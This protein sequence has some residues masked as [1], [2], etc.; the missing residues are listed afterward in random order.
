MHG[1]ACSVFAASS[2]S[3][4][5]LLMHYYDRFLQFHSNFI[6]QSISSCSFHSISSEIHSMH[7]SH[8][9]F[10]HNIRIRTHLLCFPCFI[11]LRVNCNLSQHKNRTL[12]RKFFS[13][14]WISIQLTDWLW[15][16][17]KIKIF[18]SSDNI[19]F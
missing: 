19:H 18:H 3:V 1:T 14:L 6:V 7:W 11:F 4:Q 15:M 5:L 13:L 17:K 9:Y 2:L 16:R 10:L 8:F 12:F